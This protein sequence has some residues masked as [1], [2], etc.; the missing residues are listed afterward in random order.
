MSLAHAMNG[1]QL[2]RASLG[3]HHAARIGFGAMQIER[4]TNQPADAV[5]L[6]RRAIDLGVDH[7]DT[8]QFYGNGFANEVIRQVLADDSERWRP[9]KTR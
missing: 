8:A 5:K 7:V 6:L 3:T 2:K 9:P 4:L 1:G